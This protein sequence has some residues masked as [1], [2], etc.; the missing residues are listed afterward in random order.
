M[1]NDE[2]WQRYKRD[3]IKHM[4]MS[5]SQITEASDIDPVI[6]AYFNF[7]QVK[8]EDPISLLAWIHVHSEINRMTIIQNIDQMLKLKPFLHNQP[9]D[10]IAGAVIQHSF[11]SLKNI[12]NLWSDEK[13]DD[14]KQWCLTYQ[15]IVSSI[16]S[17]ALIAYVH[18]D[19]NSISL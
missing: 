7:N 10:T 4:C 18:I 14:L 13:I 6:D 17:V 19:S 12:I 16:L 11:E 1:L 5:D 8:S 9:H 3:F 15:N 2:L